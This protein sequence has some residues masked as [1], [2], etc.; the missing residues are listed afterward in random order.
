M[1]QKKERLENNVVLKDHEILHLVLYENGKDRFFEGP[2]FKSSAQ[3]DGDLSPANIIVTFADGT[4]SIFEESIKDR[5]PFKS[6][7]E[8]ND[9]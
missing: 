7:G 3:Y 4:C 2:L 5:L 9:K 1:L 6:I 8:N